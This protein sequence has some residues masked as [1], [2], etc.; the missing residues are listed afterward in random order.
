MEV[1]GSKFALQLLFPCGSAKKKKKKKTLLKQLSPRY[2][3]L[4]DVIFLLLHSQLYLW[5]SP[6]LGDISVYLTVF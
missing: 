4:T 2:T 1:L 3:L 6:F 5:G